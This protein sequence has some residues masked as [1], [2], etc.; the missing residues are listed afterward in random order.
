M[1]TGAESSPE[2]TMS[3][4]RSPALSRSP[5]PSQQ[6]R[7]GRPWKR[8]RSPARRI[9]RARD[10]FCGDSASGKRS[11]TAR[12]VFAMSAGSPDRAAQRKGPLPSQNSG[13][14]YAGTKPGKAKARS[15]PAS[16]AS[17]RM[18]LP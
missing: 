8:T 2:A 11:R 1:T 7:A 18:E 10:A 17:P 16:R 5:Y 12:S 15:Y 9:Q 13:R 6:M 3:L 4:N 14:M